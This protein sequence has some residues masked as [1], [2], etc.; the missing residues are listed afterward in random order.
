VAVKLSHD[1]KPVA[2]I[3]DAHIFQVPNAPSLSV[4]VDRSIASQ[5][6][7]NQLSVATM[8]W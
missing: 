1:L 8:C 5:L 3:V 4:N 6:G 2:G 7:M